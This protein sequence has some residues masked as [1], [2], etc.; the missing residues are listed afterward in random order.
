MSTASVANREQ[1][2]YFLDYP[3]T[4]HTLAQLV[5]DGEALARLTE[6]VAIAFTNDTVIE[7]DDRI[8]RDVA[9]ASAAYAREIRDRLLRAPADIL[10]MRADKSKAE[11][12]A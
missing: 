1:P 11:E 12:A 8:L 6:L 7:G 5:H 4:G 10:E 2:H 9:S 3:T